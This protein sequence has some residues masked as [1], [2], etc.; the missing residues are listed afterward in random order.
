MTK[1]DHVPT[2]INM[3]GAL[4]ILIPC[5]SFFLT[6]T[7]QLYLFEVI[8][9]S[10]YTNFHFYSCTIPLIKPLHVFFATLE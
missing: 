2:V 6:L 3:T 9:K 8:K 1:N 10:W 5:N 7:E 4:Y